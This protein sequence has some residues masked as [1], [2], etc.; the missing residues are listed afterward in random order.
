LEMPLTEAAE[1]DDELD[2]LD[3]ADAF[4]PDPGYLVATAADGLPDPLA[5]I[6]EMLPG[7]RA[8]RGKPA[9]AFVSTRLDSHLAPSLRDRP[10]TL[11]VLS[12]NAGDGKTTFLA[13]LIE[14]SGGVYEPGVRNEYD[15]DLAPG[16][17][18]RVV[19][20]GSEDAENRTNDALLEEALSLFQGAQ[21][22]DHVS[23]GT[24]IAINKGRLLRFLQARSGQYEYLWNLVK[25]YSSSEIFGRP[26]P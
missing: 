3:E 18:Y 26:N 13:E 15:V 16:L 14:S 12:G 4:W 20:D 2:S 25:A 9:L 22:V 23:R 17:P 21:P 6:A 8:T 7:G 10:P 1:G 24:L 11:V 19:L 5:E